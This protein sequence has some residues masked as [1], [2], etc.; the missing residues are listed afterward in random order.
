MSPIDH[1]NCY[2]F[3]FSPPPPL[4]DHFR[5]PRPG[6]PSLRMLCRV[7]ARRIQRTR[8][9]KEKASQISQ[10]VLQW[11]GAH[12][13][14]DGFKYFGY[15]LSPKKNVILRAF[16]TIFSLIYS[17]KSSFFPQRA[18][19]FIFCILYIPGQFLSTEIYL[20]IIDLANIIIKL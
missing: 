2:L 1:K 4:L 12:T 5:R 19:H 9:R 13:F 15:S 11:P 17:P 6:H 20:I 10:I 7:A 18:S 8:F 16:C 14:F 3:V